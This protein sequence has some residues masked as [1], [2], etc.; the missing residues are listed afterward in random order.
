VNGLKILGL[1]LLLS[2]CDDP[3]KS[4]ELVAEPRVLGARVEVE[5]DP[6]RAAPAPGEAATV[7]LLV[8]SPEPSPAFG[9]ALAAC[10]AATRNGARA[11]CDGEVFARAE[12]RD[13]EEEAVRLSFEVPKSLDPSGRV[14]VYGVVCP[15][16]APTEDGGCDDGSA[17]SLQR[18]LELVRED[19]V[20]ENPELE[21]DSIRF[22]DVEWPALPPAL[23][24]CGGLGFPEVAAQ[25][26]HSLTVQLSEDDRDPLPRP[27]ELDPAREA[28]QLSHFVSDGDISRAFESISWDSDELTRTATWKAPATPGL[29][30]FWLVLRDLRGG[31]AF[32]ERAVCVK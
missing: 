27:S 29:V 1:S 8:A 10:P 9:F 28:L 11:A 32:S 7:T 18:E 22:D 3:L 15:H 2:A 30:R 31:G 13:G 14:L 19:D 23:G 21:P 24:D 26:D 17:T 12:S 16:G 5:G 4:V 6:H 20:N 25:S